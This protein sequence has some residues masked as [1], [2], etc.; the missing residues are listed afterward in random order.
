MARA[1]QITDVITHHGEGP[2]WDDRANALRVVDIPTGDIVTL[3]DGAIDRLH[4]GNVA[5]AWRPRASGGLVVAVERGFVLVDAAMQIEKSIEAWTDPAVRMNDG[6][7]DRHGSFYCG[8]MA[9]QKTPSAASVYRLDPDGTVRVVLDN[10]TISNGM[11]WSATDDTAYYIDT[12]TQR[13]D[14]IR[15]D[16]QSGQF[17]DRHPV[18]VMDKSVGSPDGMTVDADGG[19]WVAMWGGGAVGHFAADGTLIETIEVNA[20]QVTAC[21]FGGTDYGTLYITTS[22]ENLKDGEDPKAGAIF[23]YHPQVHGVA[24]LTFAG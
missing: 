14:T 24:Q 5:A 20:R 19:L 11:A 6:A 10:V 21:T 4:V 12:A 18:V 2:V 17:V 16:P 9:Y 22:R 8:S 23:A 3:T 1:E 15:T 7:C 13:V